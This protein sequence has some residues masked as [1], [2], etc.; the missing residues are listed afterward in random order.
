VR[1]PTARMPM[2]TPSPAAGTS[3]PVPKSLAPPHG[4]SPYVTT[5]GANLTLAASPNLP[6]STTPTHGTHPTSVWM[7]KATLCLVPKPTPTTATIPT[8]TP[9]LAVRVTKVRDLKCA[10]RSIKDRSPLNP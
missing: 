2:D 4:A 7:S 10:M 9:T 8:E 3:Q 6:P 5:P 1:P